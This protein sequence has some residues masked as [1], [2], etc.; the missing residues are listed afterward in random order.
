M[1]AHRE[2]WIAV[3]LIVVIVGGMFTFWC[4]VVPKIAEC[5]VLVKVPVGATEVK[6]WGSEYFTYKWKD[7]YFYV[8]PQ[9]TTY[10]P[11][12]PE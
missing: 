4:A 9:G 8:T 6:A 7:M 5:E 11:K 10:I 12:K 1:R 2:L 3:G